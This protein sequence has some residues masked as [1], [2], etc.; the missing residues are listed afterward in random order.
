MTIESLGIGPNETTRTAATDAMLSPRFYTTNFAEMD[1]LDVSPVRAEWDALIAEMRADP[2][3]MHF[4][5]TEAWDQF[6]L[7]K[8]P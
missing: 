7:A 5:R 8:L 3:K 4:R 1:Q 2:N 6:E